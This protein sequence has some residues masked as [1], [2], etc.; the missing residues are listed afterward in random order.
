M[1]SSPHPNPELVEHEH[2][3]LAIEQLLPRTASTGD[4]RRF[5]AFAH[6]SR[7]SLD[8]LWTI[9]GRDGLPGIC[10]MAVPSEGRTTMIFTSEV[11]DIDT[12][13]QLTRLLEHATAFLEEQPVD[14]AQGLLGPDDAI[15]QQAFLD[16]GFRKLA[17]LQYMECET[18]PHQRPP[19]VPGDLKLVTYDESRREDLR[20]TLEASYEETLDCPGLRGLRSTDDVIKGHQ[21]T[22]HYDASLWTLAFVKDKPVGCVLINESSSGRQ[23]ELVYLGLSPQARGKGYGKIMARHAM[24]LAAGQRLRLLS[25][26]V[27][28]NNKPALNLYGSL[29]FT[30]T[31]H[32][33]AVIRSTRSLQD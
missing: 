26:A 18:A 5:I 7:I 9:R 20:L 22:G 11:Q 17:T 29:G 21:S 4:A 28:M 31:N 16:A 1:A 23:A 2:Q 33:L 12:Q 27:D 24:S 32:R 13:Q 10:V 6:R 14:L 15:G 3:L 25:L 30:A 8:W 19:V